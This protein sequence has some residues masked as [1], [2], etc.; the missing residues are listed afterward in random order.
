M[1][2][3]DASRYALTSCVA[4]ALLAGCGGSQPPIG[5]PTL[6]KN[7]ASGSNGDL[8]YVTTVRSVE[9]WSYPG[10]QLVGQSH[11]GRHHLHDV[12]SDPKTG[13]VFIGAA[14]VI[15]RYVHGGTR[16]VS[17]VRA[18]LGYGAFV[19]CSVDPT[20]GDL[21][22]ATAGPQ[23]TKGALVI[24]RGAKGHGT[25]Y[26]SGTG[27]CLYTAYDNAHDVFVD[28]MSRNSL[29]VVL[30]ELGSGQ[31]RMLRINIHPKLA[32][33]IKMQWEGNYL[34]LAP[35]SGG[36][37]DQ[38]RISGAVGRV[39]HSTQLDDATGN[40]VY[41]IYD[42]A[43]LAWYD[44]VRS[45]GSQAV[46]VWNYPSGGKPIAEFYGIGNKGLRDLTISVAPTSRLNRQ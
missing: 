46:G 17:K 6:A 27:P 25:V 37:I 9:T 2:I 32:F 11:L 44:K 22:V 23:E 28:C 12:C 1:T 29:S 45:D 18:P 19:G 21:A 10:G 16:P 42:G 43:V 5:A 40:Y 34:T 41:W 24:Y 4:V 3:L 33:P 39:V 36:T 8:L 31:T 20:N 38:V 7:T 30:R 35:E 13:D 15:L 26:P 14:D